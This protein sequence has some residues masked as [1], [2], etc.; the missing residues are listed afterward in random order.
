VP[1]ASV[2]RELRDASVAV[3]PAGVVDLFV[4]FAAVTSDDLIDWSD[5]QVVFTHPKI[6]TYG[7]PTESPFVVP[8]NGKYYLFVCTNDPYNTSAVYES[9]SPYAWNIAN[10][11]G[12]FPSH[13]AEVIQDPADKNWYLSRAGWGQGGLYLAPLSWD[14]ESTAKIPD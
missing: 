8:R 7:G 13:A 2:P 4:K 5:K 12:T 3:V 9:A 11:V 10:E 14:H 1:C 6:G